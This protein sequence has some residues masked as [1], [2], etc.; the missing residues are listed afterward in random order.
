MY[1]RQVCTTKEGIK[2]YEVKG[3]EIRDNVNTDF[4]LGC[5]DKR[6]DYIP[7]QE[8]WIELLPDTTDM[9]YNL[10]HELAER[11]IM[12][13]GGLPYRSAHSFAL[14]MEKKARK[15]GKC[16]PCAE[17]FSSEMKEHILELWPLFI[18]PEEPVSGRCGRR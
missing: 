10:Q 16:Q 5:H 14:Q 8:V 18:E 9:C 2:V 3:R 17:L 15:T 6:C 1:K 7:P 11:W 12:A 4:A 13:E